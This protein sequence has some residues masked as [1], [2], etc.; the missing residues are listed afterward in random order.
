[1]LHVPLY[2]TG[3]LTPDVDEYKLLPVRA[4]SWIGVLVPSTQEWSYHSVPRPDGTEMS[5]YD[6]EIGIETRDLAHAERALSLIAA[7]LIVVQG[8]TFFPLDL[9]LVDATAA[10]ERTSTRSRRFR[11]G[12]GGISACLLAAR[13]SW[14]HARAYALAKLYVSMA[15]HST[16]LMDLHPHYS[17]MIPRTDDPVVH[18]TLAQAIFLAYGAIEEL[19]LEVRASNARP[20][21][22]NG[23]WN[24]PVL[25]DLEARLRAAHVN[26]Y[27]SVLWDVRG[28]KTALE[29]ARPPRAQRRAPWTRWPDIRDVD[30]ALVDAIAHVSWLRSSVTAHGGKRELVRLLSAYDVANAQQVA[31]T[32]L[33]SHLGIFDLWFPKAKRH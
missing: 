13:A 25:A 16:P 23:V 3:L 30:V 18:A 9:E 26:P 29:M 24:P 6:L 4:S 21:S 31:R 15:L 10:R 19:G 22:I 7:A 27:M 17:E 11:G 12:S 8:S 28:R 32:L 1:M 20:S 2:L 14:R 33:L 5:G